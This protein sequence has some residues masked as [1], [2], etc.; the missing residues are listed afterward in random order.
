MPS[1][2]TL[3]S[4][5]GNCLQGGGKIVQQVL[6]LLPEG[7]IL[8]SDQQIPAGELSCLLWSLFGQATHFNNWEKGSRLEESRNFTIHAE[9][10][11]GCHSPRKRKV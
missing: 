7:G 3:T 11:G 4:I 9:V 1:R 10:L 6:Q 5:L 8:S 2:V